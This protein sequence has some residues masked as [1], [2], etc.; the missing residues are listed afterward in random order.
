[1]STKAAAGKFIRKETIW[2]LSERILEDELIHE[3]AILLLIDFSYI[4]KCANLPGSAPK[5]VL[6]SR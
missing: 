6:A 4:L 3:F 2:T 5:C 1:M